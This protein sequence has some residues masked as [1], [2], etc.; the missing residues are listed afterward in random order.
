MEHPTDP[1]CEL[2][3]TM[4]PDEACA[5]LFAQTQSGQLTG[6]TFGRAIRHLVFLAVMGLEDL[7][8]DDNETPTDDLLTMPVVPGLPC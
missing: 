5:F 3:E 7:T 4:G 8:D 1:I 6:E 2:L